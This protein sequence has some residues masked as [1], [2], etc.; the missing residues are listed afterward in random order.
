MQL[1]KTEAVEEPSAVESD[2]ENSFLRFLS[3]AVFELYEDGN[4]NK[5]LDA[6]DPLIGT[7][8]EA[9]GGFHMAE[10]LLAK[11]YFVKEKKAPEAISPTKRRITLRSPRTVR[12]L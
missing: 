11:G 7:L 6:D 9:D 4:G 10:D 3:G 2:K 8:K 1:H 12:L 5:E